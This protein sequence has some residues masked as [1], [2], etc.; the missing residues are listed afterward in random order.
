[1]PVFNKRTQGSLEKRLIPSLGQ[2]GYKISL[3]CLVPESRGPRGNKK[4]GHASAGANLRE[5]Q[6]RH[7]GSLSNTINNGMIAL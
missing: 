6:D 1:M 3:E 5:T 2:E 4:D 7:G